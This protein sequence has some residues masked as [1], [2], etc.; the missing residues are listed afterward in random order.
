MANFEPPSFSLGLD[1]DTQLDPPIAIRPIDPSPQ[2]PSTH[3]GVLGDNIDTL[4]QAEVMDS[5]PEPEPETTRVLKRLRRGL[6]AGPTNQIVPPLSEKK[7]EVERRSC[8]V[9]GDDEIEEFS[10]Q[11]EDLLIRDRHPSAQHQSVCSSSKIPLRGH[12]VFTTQPLRKSGKREQ[13]SDAPSSASLAT[14]QNGWMFPKLTISP[15]RKFQLLDSD[16]ELDTDQPS[17]SKDVSK[18]ARRINSSSKE[19]ECSASEQ[20]KTRPLDMH[21]NEDLWKDLCPTKSSQIPTPVLDEFCQEYFQSAKNKGTASD[22]ACVGN[23]KGPYTYTNSCG[24]FEQCWDSSDPLPPSHHYFFHDDPR[25]QK[26]VRSRLPNFSPL[27]IVAKRGNQQPCASVIDYMSQFSNGEASKHKGTQKIINNKSSTRGRKKSGQPNTQDLHAS[28]GWVDPNG[29]AIP[30]DAGKRRVHANGQSA[31]HWYTS[32][33]G[34][35]VYISRSGQE[36]TGQF[37]YRQYRKESGIKKSKKKTGSKNK[38]AKR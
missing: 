8:G 37:A 21:H 32:R 6:G 16:S 38:N 4:E 18:G 7:Q 3:A 9:N 25:I 10:S 36:L 15:L 33:E 5:D 1:L 26:L 11:E 29:S 2:A 14:N 24:N 35:K 31:G 12:G 34:R 28:E 20:K 23:N 17:I 30:K 27:G 13:G 19:A 22:D